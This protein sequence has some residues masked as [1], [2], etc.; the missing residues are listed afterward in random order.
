MG[1]MTIGA[2]ENRI[3]I[4]KN[5]SAIRIV[6]KLITTTKHYQVPICAELMCNLFQPQVVTFYVVSVGL[7]N[8][9]SLEDRHSFFIKLRTAANPDR[10]PCALKGVLPYPIMG[11]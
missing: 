8:R 4:T 7:R 5:F 9:T 10:F 3:P 2:M 6:A 1:V 11:G